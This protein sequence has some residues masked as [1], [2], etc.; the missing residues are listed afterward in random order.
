[1]NIP[2]E[3]TLPL[4]QMF[5]CLHKPASQPSDTPKA[6]PDCLGKAQCQ[7]GVRAFPA[8]YHLIQAVFVVVQT[9]N[10]QLHQ[11]NLK[12]CHCLATKNHCE[13][14][15]LQKTG[16]L[17]LQAEYLTSSES[18]QKKKYVENSVF[19]MHHTMYLYGKLVISAYKFTLGNRQAALVIFQLLP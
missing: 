12:I 17:Y 2:R 5:P 8:S 4:Q 10:A 19:S 13:E 3:K 14:D 15:W 16:L 6:K 1:M 9:K 18:Q 11:G 7:A